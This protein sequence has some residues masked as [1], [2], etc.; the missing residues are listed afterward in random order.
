[1]RILAIT[2]ILSVSIIFA[3]CT[4]KPDNHKKTTWE[5][6]ELKGKVKSLRLTGY[7]AITDTFGQIG[8]GEIIA[9]EWGFNNTFI[10]YDE[11]GKW[12]EYNSYE[13]DG[14]II[15]KEVPEYDSKGNAIAQ[16]V[17]NKGIF[18]HKKIYVN[19][20]GGNIVEVR[21]YTPKDSLIYKSLFKYDENGNNI[22]SYGYTPDS[23][24]GKTVSKYDEKGNCIEENNYRAGK[25]LESKILYKY[26]SNGKMIEKNSYDSEGKSVGKTTY[27]YNE[28]GFKTEICIYDSEGNLNKKTTCKY[29]YDT[30]GNWIAKIDYES[31]I[32][33]KITERQIEYY[34]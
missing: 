31:D 6:D 3:A 25:N 20:N 33:T 28:E 5:F 17:Y 15:R 30:D 27:R 12:T 19:D 23:L 16:Y 13:P 11:N 34:K 24:V 18:D 4:Q 14:S 32:A 7:T 8:K 10:Q 26:D 1:M 29:K 9:V 2:G 22:E 21:K